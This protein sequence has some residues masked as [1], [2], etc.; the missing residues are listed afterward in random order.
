MTENENINSQ[1]QE[2]VEAFQEFL[3]EARDNAEEWQRDSDTTWAM[4]HGKAGQNGPKGIVGD[5]I[6]RV[7]VVGSNN[8]HRGQSGATRIHMNRVGLAQ[9]QLKTQFKQ[10]LMN[11]DRWLVVENVEGLESVYMTDLEAKRAVKYLTR[12]S[13]LKAVL[14]DVIG[15]G[16]AENR[17]SLK[18]VTSVKEV[19]GPGGKTHKRVC[20][21]FVPLNIYNYYE[22][23]QESGLYR[24]HEAALDKWQVLKKCSEDGTEK[25]KPYILKK[26]KDLS[27]NKSKHK[28]T[29]E[30]R[31]K[32]NDQEKMKAGRRQ[33][34]IIHEFW[35][36][37][38]DKDGNIMEYEKSDGSKMM[39]ENVVITFGNEECMLHEPKKNPRYT[40]NSP[41][42]STRILRTNLNEFGRAPLMAGVEMNRA[43]NKLIGSIIDAAIQSQYNVKI[44]KAK[45]L[46][47]PEQVQGGVK[48]NQTIL[49]NDELSPGEKLMETLRTGQVDP[50]AFQVLSEIQRSGAENMMG[51][52]LSVSG[53]MPSKQ[54]RATE[55][56]QSQSVING[57][58]ETLAA[59]IEDT[60][61]EPLGLEIFHE[62]LQHS[63]KLSDEGLAY[64]FGG[65]QERMEAFKELS[66]TEK[67]EEL[68]HTFRFRGKGLRGLAANGR[69]AQ[70][71]INLFN[72][73]AANPLIFQ[74]FQRRGVDLVAMFDKIVAGMNLDMQEFY[75][76]AEADF[77]KIS[78]LIQEQALAQAAAQ[79]QSVGQPGG[80]GAQAPQGEGPSDVE[81]GSGAGS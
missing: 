77:A 81:P 40:G 52:E 58:F 59:D 38:L 47:K 33:K 5:G 4:I 41:F 51:S 60:L 50:G 30:N 53:G 61:I 21:E 44:I 79:G 6:D 17:I 65:N 22:D 72:M 35:G 2:I 49:Q 34:V 19:K 11:F 1:E 8:K 76:E 36:T 56:V 10:G 23:T 42:L 25:G 12:D 26:V 71:L 28:E 57:L 70:T 45:G 9:Q 69:Q 68:G 67:F 64:V 73:V 54:V 39:L 46:A 31:S 18:L 62:F 13:D 29:D 63:D 14:S 55:V 75:N 74:A 7:R 48:P 37:I 78:Q 43:E 27:V 3:Q 24:I 16:A 15:I 32:G 20:T 80:Q 66:K